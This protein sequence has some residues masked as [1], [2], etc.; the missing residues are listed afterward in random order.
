MN[1]NTAS[2]RIVAELREKIRS[3]ALAPG[4]RVPSARAL[5][6]SHGVALATA[7]KVIDRLRRERLVRVV[8]GVGTVV[9]ESNLGPELSLARIVEAAIAIADDEGLAGLSMRTVATEVGVPTMSIYRHV[10]SKDELVLAMIDTVMAALRPPMLRRATW[11]TK[12][13]AIA[14]V[15]WEGY[16]R[17][18]WLAPA[19]SMTR[20]QLLPNGMAH[21]EWILEALDE[22]GM[23]AGTT[24]RTS[25]AFIAHIRGMAMSLEAERD[26]E[27]DTGMSSV[28]WMDA[29]ES[30]FAG[31]L[32]RFPTLMRL[33]SATDVDITL[34]AL[35][36][37]GLRCFLDGI[38]AQSEAPPRVSA[39]R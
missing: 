5:M 24:L 18:P 23:D 17:H 33:S 28:E 34:P 8:P 39:R 29:Q 15:H 10:P 26:A 4:T 25:I 14:R 30:R 21:T 3:G 27:R 12:L 1:K 35:F 2:E 19:L 9:R 37:C 16:V 32:S 38:A 31:M 13:E 6:R 22:L 36:E 20:P 7:A 11:R